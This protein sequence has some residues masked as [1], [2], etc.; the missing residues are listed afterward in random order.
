[1][2]CGSQICLWHPHLVTHQIGQIHRYTPHIMRSSSRNHSLRRKKRVETWN[3]R[4]QIQKSLATTLSHTTLR[5][6]WAV[7][8]PVA[9]ASTGLGFIRHILGKGQDLGFH[10]FLFLRA[11]PQAGAYVYS[12]C[13]LLLFSQVTQDLGKHIHWTRNKVRNSRTTRACALV[14]NTCNGISDSS[15]MMHCDG[16]S[17]WA[18]MIDCNT[19]FSRKHGLEDVS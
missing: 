14:S 2:W 17:G 19:F 10:I 15:N 12:S 7:P 8:T 11:W 4:I 18:T 13:S 1:M 6:T 3:R 5:I 9:T 16:R